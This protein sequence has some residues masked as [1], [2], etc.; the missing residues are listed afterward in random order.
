MTEIPK[1]TQKLDPV[2]AQK[3]LTRRITNLTLEEYQKYFGEISKVAAN[4]NN[5]S[6][7]LHTPRK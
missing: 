4:P 2:K 1:P 3:I 7:P 5:L 6:F